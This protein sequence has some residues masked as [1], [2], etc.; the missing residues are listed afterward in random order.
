MQPA[1]LEN[2]QVLF[3]EDKLRPLV[4][5]APVLSGGAVGETWASHVCASQS[6][7]NMKGNLEDKARAGIVSFQLQC[8]FFFGGELLQSPPEIFSIF[9]D[10]NLKKWYLGS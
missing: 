4:L 10:P 7:L 3:D 6:R 2:R 9:V 1:V 5:V 8:C